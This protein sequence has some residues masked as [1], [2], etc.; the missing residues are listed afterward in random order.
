MFE[1][2][3]I[4]VQLLRVLGLLGLLLFALSMSYAVDLNGAGA[5]F[6]YPLYSKWFEVSAQ[7]GGARINYQSIGSGGGIKAL[8]DGTVD[9]GASDAPLS[10]DETRQMHGP[11]VTL[12]MVA[13]AVALA[14]NLPGE[15]QGVKL[16]PEAI[17]GI[18]LG[19]ITHWDDARIKSQNG[20]MNLPHMPITVV[21]RSD[22]SGT[23]YIFTQYLASISNTWKDKVGVGKSV[24]WP[25]GLGG[26]GSEGVAGMVR[27][28][29]GS[30]GYVELAYAMQ[31]RMPYAQVRNKSG[32]FVS[33]NTASTTAAAASALNAVK[34][35]IGAPIVNA[36]GANAYPIAGFTYIMLYRNQGDQVK[37]S[38]TVKFLWW[39]IHDGQKYAS[40]L[41]YAPLP[42]Q[43][44]KLDEAILKSV[45]SNG[46]SLLK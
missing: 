28:A 44:M 34:A 10:A 13:G 26:K 38:A 40:A 8:K 4:N 20:R 2:R 9:F 35:E 42:K 43:I 33:P 45:G 12:P 23:S 1:T 29:P 24:N 27:Q 15:P 17:A 18:F 21:H 3:T 11:V 31:N 41:V 22:G 19:E 30:I 32:K 25:V 7:A 46:K 6:P 37:G 14:Y 39:A 5:T 16:T 36:S